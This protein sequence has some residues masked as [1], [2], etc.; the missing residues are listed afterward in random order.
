MTRRTYSSA[1]LYFY[2]LFVNLFTKNKA[3]PRSIPDC[4]RNLPL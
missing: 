4:L 3:R 2:K 1:I